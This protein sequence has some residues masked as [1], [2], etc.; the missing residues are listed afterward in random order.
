MEESRRDANL[1]AAFYAGSGWHFDL[2]LTV[3]LDACHSLRSFKARFAIV[4]ASV[5]LVLGCI[6]GAAIGEILHFAPAG[7]APPGN[8]MSQ[9]T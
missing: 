2:S 6:F 5:V 8:G 3:T 7:T 1:A 4:V 9:R